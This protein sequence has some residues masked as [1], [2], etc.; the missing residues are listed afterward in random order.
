MALLEAMSYG[1]PVIVSDIPA[2]LE[3][4]LPAKCYFPGGDIDSLASLLS[5]LCE[6]PLARIDYDMATYYCDHIA[7]EVSDVYRSLQ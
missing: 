1:L 6:D 2:N 7:K 4:C 3:V 5:V